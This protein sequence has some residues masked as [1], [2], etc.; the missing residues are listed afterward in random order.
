MNRTA[1][2]IL[3]TLDEHFYAIG[4]FNL[5][6]S[7]GYHWPMNGLGL[8]EEILQKIYRDNALKILNNSPYQLKNSVNNKNEL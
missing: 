5:P 1:F 8:D 6:L 7:I 4:F 3:E 2:R